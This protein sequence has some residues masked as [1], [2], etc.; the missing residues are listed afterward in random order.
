[1]AAVSPHLLEQTVRRREAVFPLTGGGVHVYKRAAD[2]D[3]AIWEAAFGDSHKDF[4]YYQLIEETM[5][6]GFAYRYLLLCDEHRDPVALQP[7]VMVDQDLAA[8]MEGTIGRVIGFIRKFWPRFLR[9][10]MLLAGCLVG[11]SRPGV[12]AP[13]NPSRVSALLAEA[14]LTYAARQKISLISAKDFPAVLRDELFPFVAAGYTRL[15]GFPPLTLDLNFP[16]FDRYMETRLSRTTRKGLRRKLR[17]TEKTRPPITLEVLSDCRAVID[18]IYPLYLNVARRAPVEFEIFSRE[19][20]L[21]AGRRMQDR[22]RY[23]V[24]RRGG[25]AIAFSFCTVWNDEFHDNDIGLDYEVA[26]E[27]NLYYLTFHDLIVWALQHGLRSY[28]CAPFNYDPKLHLRLQPVAVDL[29]VRHRSAPINLLLKWFAPFFAPA[30]S[31]PAL[32]KFRNA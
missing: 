24:W 7:L 10:R 18:E 3:P 5:T 28:H 13:A 27:L 15:G 19:Y 26:H 17:K 21:E 20:F 16:T 8:T 11:H 14:L 23:F 22:H 4:D 6:S 32:R 1:M 29:Y 25:K 2:V 30:K 12:I 31:D 9:S